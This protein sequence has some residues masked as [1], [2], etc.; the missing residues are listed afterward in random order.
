MIKTAQF[1]WDGAL[2]PISESEEFSHLKAQLAF[3][4]A[5]R[6]Q[7]TNEVIQQTQTKF[8]NA[9]VVFG[10][11][12]GHFS[13][14][15]VLFDQ[16][17]ITGVSFE[18]TKLEIFELE[19]ACLTDKEHP[20]H[21]KVQ[22]LLNMPDI[23][24]VLV[25]SEGSSTNGSELTSCLATC[26]PN[27]IP[28]FGGMT[29]DM[30]RFEK[31]YAGINELGTTPKIVIIGFIG[32]DI[33]FNF[34]SEGGWHVFGPER[35]IT[36]SAKNVLYELSHQNALDLYKE[37]LGEYSAMLPASS[38]YFPLSV[39]S[40]D[41]DRFFVR[42]V[43]SINENNKS[44]TFAGDVPQGSTV[45][46]MKSNKDLLLDAAQE[47]INKTAFKDA[48][49]QLIFLISCVGRKIVLG[50]RHDEELELTLQ[51]YEHAETKP[52]VTG[53]YSYGE[54]APDGNFSPCDLYNQT[55]TITSIYEQ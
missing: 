55:I 34:G 3:I 46:F 7:L 12:S 36:A 44:M 35:T 48:V 1:T 40:P 42:T 37:Y 50:S 33:H 27:N 17:V 51:H 11:T 13:N 24:A 31:T 54:I 2:T 43:L 52:T 10:T 20:S 32:K 39:K 26:N 28:V 29:A 49:P 21:G 53:F 45:R 4:F 25:L 6:L 41:G 38:L 23:K 16:P 5:D 9:T 30:E 14:Q 47:A 15:E 19:A 8:P 22:N 18:K